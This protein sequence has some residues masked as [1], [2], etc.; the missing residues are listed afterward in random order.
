MVQNRKLAITLQP[1]VLRFFQPSFRPKY[2]L[3]FYVYIGDNIRNGESFSTN[4]HS[5]GKTISFYPTSFVNVM[6]GVAK[7]EKNIVIS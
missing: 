7:F 1:L 2:G 6:Q 4:L 3:L 5:M